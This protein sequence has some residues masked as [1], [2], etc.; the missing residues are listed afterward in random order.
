MRFHR[1]TQVPLASVLVASGVVVG[2]AALIASGP[3][4]ASTRNVLC[5]QQPVEAGDRL[6]VNLAT[7]EDVLA[8]LGTE[9]HDGGGRDR[10]AGDGCSGDDRTGVDFEPPAQVGVRLKNLD[11]G[12]VAEIETKQVQEDIDRVVE[13]TTQFVGDTRDRVVDD[14]HGTLDGAGTQ[15]SESVNRTLADAYDQLPADVRGVLDS[16]GDNGLGGIGE[17]I[18]ET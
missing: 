4:E 8:G 13:G 18:P 9:E 12:P 14:A 15:V 11:A 5:S 3:V 6:R 2:G 10:Q 7:L 16:V 17:P 1:G